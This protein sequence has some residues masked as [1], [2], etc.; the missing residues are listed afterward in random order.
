[1]RVADEVG[2]QFTELFSSIGFFSVLAGILLL[3]NIFVMLAQERKG[4]LGMLR[5]VGMRRASLVGSFALEGW[6]YAL[7][8][9]AIGAVAG[10]GVGRVIV[11]VAAG[12]FAQPGEFSLE[13][14]Y[15]A[16]GSSVEA[17]F[18]TGFIMAL[19]TV[20][21]TAVL[22]A[23][24]NVIR[25]VRDLPDPPPRRPRQAPALVGAVLVV[26]GAL[27]VLSGAA[28]SS[29]TALLIGPALGALGVVPLIGRLAPWLP[30]R[31]V[32]TVA[33]G[34][35]L[36]WAVMCFDLVPDAFENSPITIFVVEGV[37]LVASAVTLV[38]PNQDALGRAVRRVGRSGHSLAVRLGLA[39]P[40][41][42]RFRTGMI[43]SMYALVV[44]TLA[45]ITLIADMFAT[46]VDEFAASLSGGFDLRLLS[47][48][49][50]PVP[51]EAVRTRPGVISVAPL[52]RVPAEFRGPDGR[53]V[54][55]PVT[56]FG[57]E[58]VA[59]GPPDIHELGP[60]QADSRAA[61]QA[62]LDDPALVLVDEFF[63]QQGGGPPEGGPE[64]GATVVLRDPL[65]G[66]VRE[67][68]VAAVVEAGFDQS[69]ALVSGTLVTQLFG[70]R[71]VPNLLYVA[72]AAG[73]DAQEVAERLNGEFVANGAD[74]ISFRRAVADGLAQQQQFFRLMQ[75]Y[76]ALGLVVGVAGLGVVMVRAVRERRRQIGVLRSLGFGARQVRRSFVVESAFIAAQGIAI[77]TVLAG[78]SMWRLAASGNFGGGLEFRVPWPD[79]AVLAVG[80][81]VASLLATAA[82]AQQASRIRP[83]VALR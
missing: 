64:P 79:M 73:T 55:Q 83:A 31:A 2:Q 5:A 6:V 21:I 34:L 58:L 65:S 71:A 13:L 1:M 14:R 62:V 47:N 28:N 60:G 74:A 11:A 53:F 38:L 3:V 72:T 57:P 17:G 33:A 22:V 43:L 66:Q 15:A 36:A 8:A 61:Y 10:L 40:L 51:V 59:G 50:N 77:G 63:L 7:V 67:L 49:A 20:V 4:E 42:R 39:Y 45:S 75:G 68:R 16:R 41:A 23:R 44:Y 56:G 52:A 80:T 9:S 81:L 26:V 54:A 69:V 78:L 30:R 12:I 29:G 37:I 24:L 27:V 25:A 76:L 32:V 18:V 82:P 46:Q 35:T 48:P 19:V 70:A